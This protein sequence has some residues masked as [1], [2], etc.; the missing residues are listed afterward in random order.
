M[1]HLINNLLKLL[2]LILVLFGKYTIRKK[3]FAKWEICSWKFKLMMLRVLLQ[4]KLLE[5]NKIKY[6]G[7]LRKKKKKEYRVKAMELF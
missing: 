3:M 6:N 7:K 2:L 4:R 1:W 5:R